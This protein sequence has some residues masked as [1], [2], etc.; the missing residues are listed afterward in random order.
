[1][2][3]FKLANKMKYEIGTGILSIWGKKSKR[4]K[5]GIL[6]FSVLWINAHHLLKIPY[7]NNTWI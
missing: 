7:H 2:L 5:F 3:I 1:M 6:N 4:R